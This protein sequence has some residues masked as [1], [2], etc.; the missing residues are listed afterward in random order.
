LNEK[1]RRKKALEQ[2]GAQFIAQQQR[3]WII[4]PSIL[5]LK[6]VQA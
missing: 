2:F 6:G 1:K 5:G 3:K 4:M